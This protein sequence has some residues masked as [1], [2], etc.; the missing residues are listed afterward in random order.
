MPAWPADGRL[1]ISPIVI[2]A[3][4]NDSYPNYGGVYVKNST[5]YKLD[6]EQLYKKTLSLKKK[7]K[8]A[9]Q[10]LIVHTHTTE[11]YAEEGATTY[12]PSFND[13][14]TDLEK[15]VAAVGRGLFARRNCVFSR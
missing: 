9:V 14:T 2:K 12:D 11:C 1:P 7:K 3:T 8:D 4:L 15:N 5:S 6:M 10:V 13:R